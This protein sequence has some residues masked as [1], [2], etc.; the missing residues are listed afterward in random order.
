MTEGQYGV[1]Q[2]DMQVMEMGFT[3]CNRVSALRQDCLNEWMVSIV[4]FS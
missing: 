3:P 4:S 2:A 1:F